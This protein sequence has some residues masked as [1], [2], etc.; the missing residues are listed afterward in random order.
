MTDRGIYRPSQQLH[1]K[2]VL[3]EQAADR[4]SATA[5]SKAAVEATLQDANGRQVSKVSLK[6]KWLRIF[7]GHLSN[8]DRITSW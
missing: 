2:G 1:F 8:S 7:S 5:V 4:R 6:T 3:I